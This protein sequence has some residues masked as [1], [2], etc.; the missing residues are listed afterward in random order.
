MKLLKFILFNR[1]GNQTGMEALQ[2]PHFKIKNFLIISHFAEIYSNKLAM[3]SFT[4]KLGI[5]LKNEGN[6][7]RK[8]LTIKFR[9]INIHYTKKLTCEDTIHLFLVG[10]F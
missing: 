6:P 5:L 10:W 9:I 1:W 4:L 3:S 8:L 7:P 2:I